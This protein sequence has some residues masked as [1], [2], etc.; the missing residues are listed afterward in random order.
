M[1][2]LDDYRRTLASLADW[3]DYLR[4][5]SGLPG[6]R[7]NLELAHAVA[8]VGDAAL[9]ERYRALDASVAPTNT[10]GEFLAFC[11]VLGL[12]RLAAEGDTGALD[13]LRGHAADPRWW[14]RE[15]VVMVL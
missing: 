11:G 13:K 5:E 10:S 1:G 8:D 2:R 12:G 15:V 7:G 3:D 14:V 4:R 6:P 9:F